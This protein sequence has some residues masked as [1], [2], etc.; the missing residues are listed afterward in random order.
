MTA[1]LV[2]KKQFFGAGPIEEHGIECCWD[3]VATPVFWRVPT[4]ISAAAVPTSGGA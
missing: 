4:V 3:H 1:T 2:D